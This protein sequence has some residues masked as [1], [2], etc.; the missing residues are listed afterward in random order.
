MRGERMFC[1]VMAGLLA[2]I[3]SIDELPGGEFAALAVD[4]GTDSVLAS[5][6]EGLYHAGAGFLFSDEACSLSAGSA[7]DSLKAIY[8]GEE[9][10]AGLPSAPDLGS[11]QASGVAEGWEVSGWVDTAEGYRNFALVARSPSGRDIGLVLLSRD[12]CCPGKADLALMMLWEAAKG[13]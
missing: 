5:T 9:G 13:L 8:A 2:A 11:G 6:G 1:L 4:L 7:M 3:P 12:L 10:F